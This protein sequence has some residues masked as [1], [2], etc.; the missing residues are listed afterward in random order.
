MIHPRIQVCG[1]E[2]AN[3]APINRIEHS[4]EKRRVEALVRLPRL[5][6]IARGARAL[7]ARSGS[8]KLVS[9]CVALPPGPSGS[10]SRSGISRGSEATRSEEHTSEL[11][12]RGH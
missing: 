9:P 4:S 11:Q 6:A 12:S 10:R 7:G 8:N 2:L 3:H 1:G 5:V